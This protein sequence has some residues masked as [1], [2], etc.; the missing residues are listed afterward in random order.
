MGAINF[1]RLTNKSALA[2]VNNQET[3]SEEFEEFEDIYYYDYEEIKEKLEQEYLYYFSITIQAGYYEGFYL[4]LSEENTR[5]IYDN[6]KEKRE[7]I[8]ELTKIKSI[9]I[10]F[11]KNGLVCGCYP[12][13]CSSYP[14]EQETIK[15]LKKII[16]EYKQEIQKAYTQTTAARAGKGIFEIMKEAEEANK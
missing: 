12:G 9:L 8:Q 14:S 10:E 5:W 1:G 6:T 7:A 16:K 4:Q 2:L 11:I 15:E 13:W 3:E